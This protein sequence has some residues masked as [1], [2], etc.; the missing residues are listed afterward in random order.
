MK[1]TIIGRT[2]SMAAM[3][4]DL[5]TVRRADDEA[6]RANARRHLAQRMGKLRGLPQKLG[7]ILSMSDEEASAHPFS[8][9]TDAAKPLPFETVRSILESTWGGPIDIVV[10]DIDPHGRA[11]S[12]GQVHKAVLHSGEQVAVKVAYPGIR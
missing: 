5:R 10:S 6:V 7:Q 11:A 1:K 9:L 2:I 8:E 12:L 3:A 4:R